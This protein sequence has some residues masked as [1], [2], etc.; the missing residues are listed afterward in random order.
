MFSLIRSV[1]STDFANVIPCGTLCS[2]L[3]KYDIVLYMHDTFVFSP[4]LGITECTQLKLWF[5][6]QESKNK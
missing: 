3:Q 4:R 6:V 5:L 2:A 1:I